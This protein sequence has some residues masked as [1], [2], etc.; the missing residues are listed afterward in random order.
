MTISK[1]FL[2]SAVKHPAATMNPLP[3][4]KSSLELLTDALGRVTSQ[5]GSLMVPNRGEQDTVG[6]ETGF[7]RGEKNPLEAERAMIRTEKDPIGSLMVP[8][9]A[10]E[11]ILD[12]E[13]GFGRAEE[14]TPGRETGILGR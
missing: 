12:G 14:D 11:D 7:S 8:D 1:D 5:L 13:T 4:T 9:R 6:A 2:A 3:L 10:E